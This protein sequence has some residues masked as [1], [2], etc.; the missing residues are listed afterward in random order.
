MGVKIGIHKL[1][2]M[3]VSTLYYKF[4]HRMFKNKLKSDT[5]LSQIRKYAY[6]SS[7]TR[8]YSNCFWTRL[9]MIGCKSGIKQPQLPEAP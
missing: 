2:I 3:A 4:L 1:H 7:A 9:D 8:H 5:R 6:V